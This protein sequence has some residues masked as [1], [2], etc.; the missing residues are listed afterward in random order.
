MMPTTINDL[1]SK[2]LFCDAYD[3][4]VMEIYLEQMALKGYFP[5]VIESNAILFERGEPTSKYYRIE[6]FTP[7][8]MSALKERYQANGWQFLLSYSLDQCCLF[9]A[10]M[11]VNFARIGSN[12]TEFI[13]KAQ[14]KK[15][16]A[17]THLSLV[18]LIC[19]VG[20]VAAF[21][22]MW[23]TG[24]VSLIGIS[25]HYITFLLIW[26]IHRRL[27]R[28]LHASLRSYHN[29][30]REPKPISRKWFLAVALSSV[31]FAWIGVILIFCFKG[32]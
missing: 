12:D 19:T 29:S 5:R 25:C 22:W 20:L 4:N 31:A 1:I 10:D 32:G 16:E 30:R 24:A 17:Y 28:S 2:R 23:D 26:L 8:E 21:I 27:Y 14:S 6:H 13:R 9:Q 11:E 7:E 18:M 15:Q 3:F